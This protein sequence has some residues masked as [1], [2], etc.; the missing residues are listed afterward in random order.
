VYFAGRSTTLKVYHKGPEFAKRDYKRLR[1]G[2]VWYLE[3]EPLQALQG[4][5]NRL[6]RVEVEIKSPKLRY[7]FGHLPCVPELSMAYL[8]RVQETEIVRVVREGSAD[9]KT[10]RKHEEVSRRLLMVYGHQLG[11]ALF[12]T[13]SSL[14]LM[15]EAVVRGRM[16]PRTFY[17]HRKQL[18]NARCSWVGTDV[19]VC[20]SS[21]VPSDFAPVLSDPRRVVGVAPQVEEQLRVFAA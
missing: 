17:R 9:M 11:N 1:D 19:F 6:L 14:T 20:E 4:E 21:E 15:G 13:W 8:E 5:A 18:E 2:A 16:T 7:D 10:V 3:G 12:G